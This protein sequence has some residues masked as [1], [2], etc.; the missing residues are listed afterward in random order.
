MTLAQLVAETLLE[1]HIRI[2]REK[3][4]HEVVYSS[5]VLGPDGKH[6][7]NRFCLDCG[8]DLERP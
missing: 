6:H 2:T 4:P 5:G 3:C 7:M 1:K 8:K